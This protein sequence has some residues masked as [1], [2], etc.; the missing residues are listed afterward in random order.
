MR[1]LGGIVTLFFVATVGVQQS[2]AEDPSIREQEARRALQEA[3][4]EAL[5]KRLR[6]LSA[7]VSGPI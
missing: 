1:T 6:E 4:K 5:A 7:K 2:R 3:Q